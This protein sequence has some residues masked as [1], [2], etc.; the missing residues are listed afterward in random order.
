M[1]T[2]ELS[3]VRVSALPFCFYFI[4]F[5]LAEL[6]TALLQPVAGLI[7]HGII[8]T[9]LLIQSAFTHEVRCRNLIVALS[10][11]PLVRIM[12]LSMPLG[13]LP[14]IYWY[15]LIYP[16]LLVAS[17][18]VMWLVGL[19]PRQVGLV[20]HGLPVQMAIGVVT[21]SAFGI[22]EYYT[23]RPQPLIA[24]LSLSHVWFPA[25]VLLATTGFVEEF[26]FRGVLQQTSEAALGKTGLIYVSAIFAV[27]H[28]GHLSAV[29]VVFV[30]SVALFFAALVKRTGSLIGVTLSHGF[31]NIFLYLIAPFILA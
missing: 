13:I 9:A 8:L 28:I 30:F 4:A 6:V 20:A 27:L 22:L 5:T 17:V 14:Q 3:R 11:V 15:L 31:I 2:S 16:P 19:K 21:G 10:L 24:E 25:F 26:I 18:V 7:C 1:Y 12:S 23:L 29:N